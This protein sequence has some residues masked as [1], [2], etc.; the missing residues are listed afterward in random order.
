MHRARHRSA[1]TAAGRGESW[2]A[3]LR[4]RQVHVQP[5]LRD[6]GTEAPRPAVLQSLPQLSPATM[7]PAADGAELNAESIG[8]LLVGQALDVAENDS[9]PVLG[10]Q[11]HQRC[12][13]VAVEVPVV[14]SLGGSGLRTA[15]T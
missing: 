4:H 3:P 8:D 10:C 13:N 15:K 14:E 7:D 6:R 9:S 2:L 1:Q 12:M 11:C 5:R